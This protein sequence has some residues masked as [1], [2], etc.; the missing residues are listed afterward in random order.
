MHTHVRGLLSLP[1]H[2][3]FRPAEFLDADASND[4]TGETTLKCKENL[5]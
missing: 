4:R 5:T 3:V 2:P 1:R